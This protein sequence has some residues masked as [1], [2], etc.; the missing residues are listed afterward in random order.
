KKINHSL[1]EL[2]IKNDL[3]L[4]FSLKNENIKLNDMSNMHL[5][6]AFYPEWVKGYQ[7]NMKKNIQRNSIIIPFKMA[8]IFSGIIVFIF[9]VIENYFNITISTQWA[10]GIGVGFPAAGVV[11]FDL[12]QDRIPI[13]SENLE[14]YGRV[15]IGFGCIVLLWTL[16]LKVNCFFKLIHII[17]NAAW[18][19]AIG[20]WMVKIS[21]EKV[22]KKITS[23]ITDRLCDK[24]I[25]RGRIETASSVSNCF[26]C[27][28]IGLYGE[29]IEQLFRI[30]D[31]VSRRRSAVIYA[32][33]YPVVLSFLF[34][35]SR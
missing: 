23:S 22:P 4:L 7:E 25:G 18:P 21:S 28:G 31:I 32:L 24:C 35:I 16:F 8:S 3:I 30:K 2:I 29:Y 26:Q 12:L 10:L 14:K 15:L 20:I 11:F 19:I 13:T 27:S 33:L 34:V 1:K 6:I 9:M 17:L 5:D